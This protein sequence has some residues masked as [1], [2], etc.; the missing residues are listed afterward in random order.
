MNFIEKKM[1]EKKCAKLPGLL[2]IYAI[3]MIVILLQL[4]SIL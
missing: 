3:G 4:R 1:S 2:A